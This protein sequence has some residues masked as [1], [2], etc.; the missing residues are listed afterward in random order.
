VIVGW[1]LLALGIGAAAAWV[2]YG[3]PEPT[4]VATIQVAYRITLPPPLEAAAAPEVLPAAGP[5]PTQPP[6]PAP[7]VLAAVPVPVAAPVPAPPVA[8]PEPAP[9]VLV[10]LP[11][12]PPPRPGPPQPVDAMTA[13]GAAPP[14]TPVQVAATP[15]PPES[16]P[17]EPAAAPPP[18]P[19][20]V[21][22]AAAR[23]PV[24]PAGRN[25]QPAWV[26]NSRAFD[27]N[28]RRKRIAIV[29][30]DM[31][32]SPAAA[33]VAIRHLPPE[34]TLAFNTYANGVAQ[35]VQRARADGHE[36]LLNLPMEPN[37]YPTIDPGPQ[38]LLTRLSGRENIERLETVLKRASGIVGVNAHLGSRF[39]QSGDAMK[40]VLEALNERGLM[41]LDSR[42]APR[43]VGGALA[44]ELRLPRAIN[45]RF[46]DIE[47]SR[48]AIDARLAEIEQ[49]A[50]DSGSAV[51]MGHPIPVTF[52][53]L[54]MW[55]P[56]LPGKG[57]VIAPITAIANRQGDR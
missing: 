23:P 15:A 52:E 8:E 18:A 17:A 25:G 3:T 50:K 56:T 39:T 14:A 42:D 45:D 4:P 57:F 38:T 10:A 51:A 47:P 5:A 1:A 22:Q 28:D 20:A 2:E 48:E 31:G 6:Q 16:R 24:R 13:A 26:A 30:T 21:A 29:L 44:G 41:Y 36:V 9:P 40:P 53:R 27:A 49:I 46:L 35:M 43:S 34:V 54:T 37:G 33:D 12:P 55:I 7:P 11:A 32:L 19:Q